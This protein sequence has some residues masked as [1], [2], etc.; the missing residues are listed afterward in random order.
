MQ[1][2]FGCSLLWRLV[3]SHRTLQCHSF[4]NHSQP[5]ECRWSLRARDPPR[6][7]PSTPRLKT[8]LVIPP[9]EGVLI[10][11]ISVDEVLRSPVEEEDRGASPLYTRRGAVP[12]DEGAPGTSARQT[13]LA[14]VAIAL[15][16]T[17]SSSALTCSCRLLMRLRGVLVDAMYG[18][19]SVVADPPRR[20]GKRQTGRSHAVSPTARCLVPAFGSIPRI[21]VCVC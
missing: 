11:M 3:S 5:Q 4:V 15:L 9:I 17:R 20:S 8:L 6:A 7:M 16:P 19:S 1:F 18:D 21:V 2:A 10:S 12:A 14:G 13:L